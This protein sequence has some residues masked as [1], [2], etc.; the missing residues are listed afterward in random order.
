MYKPAF[1]VRV[2]MTVALTGRCAQWCDVGGKGWTRP[3]SPSDVIRVR[4][5][6]T[7]QFFNLVAH[8]LYTPPPLTLNFGSCRP[9]LDPTRHY[10]GVAS[11]GLLT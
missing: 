2:Y 9:S 5:T 11:V 7:L 6:F 1:E 10:S 3:L 8:I 4:L